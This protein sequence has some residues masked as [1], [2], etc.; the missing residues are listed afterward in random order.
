M[1]VTVL[2]MEATIDVAVNGERKAVPAGTTVGRLVRELL[3]ID[4]PAAVELNLKIL[5]KAEWESQQLQA[6][7]R[8]EVVHFVGGG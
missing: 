1:A 8:V 4:G 2:K 7:D 5:K 6:G 3:K